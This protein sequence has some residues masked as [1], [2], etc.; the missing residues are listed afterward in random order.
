MPGTPPIRPISPPH[1]G[2]SSSD[3]RASEAQPLSR[4]GITSS[5]VCARVDNTMGPP[6]PSGGSPNTSGG[7]AT[8]WATTNSFGD[9]WTDS[10]RLAE[11]VEFAHA[12]HTGK[13]R[14]Y[15]FDAA[16]KVII[17]IEAQQPQFGSRAPVA[18]SNPMPRVRAADY[19]LP[20]DESIIADLSNSLTT[21]VQVDTTVETAIEDLTASFS[22]AVQVDTTVHTAI[23]DLSS[24]FATAVLAEANPSRP[25]SPEDVEMI[26]DDHNNAFYVAD[27]G[28]FF[29]M[30]AAVANVAET[31]RAQVLYP[32]RSAV[33]NGGI[34][35]PILPNRAGRRYIHAPEEPQSPDENLCV[36]LPEAVTPP[37]EQSI[38]EASGSAISSSNNA[39]V[40]QS[41]TSLE[42]VDAT[43]TTSSTTT[44]VS[45]HP[46]S[47]SVTSTGP[48]IGSPKAT[49]TNSVNSLVS[50]QVTS[51]ELIVAKPTPSSSPIPSA[52]K[53]D[54]ANT[55][56]S[57]SSTV[58]NPSDEDVN[59][60]STRN[61]SSIGKLANSQ[62]SCRSPETSIS[63][64]N[65]S[66]VRPNSS[67]ATTTSSTNVSALSSVDATPTFTTR[68]S[69]PV[70]PSVTSTGPVTGSSTA[71]IATTSANSSVSPLVTCTELVVAT[72]TSSSSPIP[73]AAIKDDEA[74]TTSSTSS[75]VT[76][77]SDKDVIAESTANSS[78]ILDLANTQSSCRSSETSISTPNT[79]A[80]QHISS[81]ATTS[82]IN[83]SVSPVVNA[84][85]TS[86]SNTSNVSTHPVSP[87]V[88]STESANAS[89]STPASPPARI[90][91]LGDVARLTRP[92][93]AEDEP[94][95]KRPKIRMRFHAEMEKQR[96]E[97]ATQL[98]YRQVA[99]VRRSLDRRH[100]TKQA[101]LKQLRAFY[102]ARKKADEEAR[103]QRNQRVRQHDESL[104]ND[105]PAAQRPKLR[106]RFH[107]VME[108]NRREAALKKAYLEMARRRAARDLQHAA[109]QQ[110]LEPQ[111]P[112]APPVIPASQPRSPMADFVSPP[113]LPAPQPVQRRQ[114]VAYVSPSSRVPRRLVN[115]DLTPPPSPAPVQRGPL[116][117]Y[118]SLP[119]SPIRPS[120]PVTPPTSANIPAIEA[121]QQP[122]TQEAAKKDIGT[123]CQPDAPKPTTT[124][125]EVQTD[126]PKTTTSTEVQTDAPKTS[127]DCATQTDDIAPVPIVNKTAT[128]ETQTPI[129][130]GLDALTQTEPASVHSVEVQVDPPV[131][132]AIEE[133]E[134]IVQEPEPIIAEP[135]PVIQEPEPEIE[136]PEP[137]IV[138]EEPAPE[139]VIFEPMPDDVDGQSDDEP[140]E[141]IPEEVDGGQNDP[142]E[143]VSE[144]GDGEQSDNEPAE[145]IPEEVDSDQDEPE[146]VNEP[147]PPM[148]D[149]DFS[150]NEVEPIPD[151]VEEEGSSAEDD[152]NNSV[153]QPIPNAQSRKR[154]RHDDPWMN[155][156]RVRSFRHA[157]LPAPAP[158]IMNQELDSDQEDEPE[159]DPFLQEFNPLTAT[160]LLQEA[161]N[162]RFIT[163]LYDGG[164]VTFQ[165][166]FDG[167]PRTSDLLARALHHPEVLYHNPGD[168]IQQVVIGRNHI[169][170]LSESGQLFTVGRANEGQLG[171]P[172]HRHL[173]PTP[174]NMRRRVRAQDDD[175]QVIVGAPEVRFEHIAA[176]GN[177]TVAWTRDGEAYAAGTTHDEEWTSE[178]F[179][180]FPDHDNEDDIDWA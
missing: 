133:P 142:D 5:E 58:T 20:I 170:M 45:S 89:S 82:N 30:P 38:G 63:T 48:V 94:D 100:V 26:V 97:A 177:I 73:P 111:V 75:N 92:R 172:R 112:S 13:Y 79:S 163:G 159:T 93:L 60:A 129:V 40:S 51:T 11:S 33:R 140:A 124:S 39:S 57:K 69:H 80:V 41:A 166:L 87:P 2:P 3:A 128:T 64:P 67:A 105:E 18:P 135:E 77:R 17:P 10:M 164:I 71:S 81:A 151:E 125:S 120:T 165:G 143:P 146:V 16:G 171:R 53:D 131:D 7:I 169:A 43:Q 23:E 50:P 174:D 55:T 173:N 108:K 149:N 157:N 139:I 134:P 175:G 35:S 91:Q 167:V 118:D 36:F 46:V 95:P 152:D 31:D 25:A 117:D 76:N 27:V 4:V 116:V 156:D 37:M 127:V 144:E 115:Y 52:S 78:S 137:E 168:G 61:S 176:S 103:E 107:V 29:A 180:R 132:P 148:D 160:R 153:D 119:P 8:V 136:E 113:T 12:F 47:P 15:R 141:P 54:E 68:N 28:D 42:A 66:T 14:D 130:F 9:S 123:E 102:E 101:Q 179:T 98:R 44:A 155:L 72:P 147:V 109:P 85:P 162:D 178:F 1:A 150:D 126:A 110:P 121:P 70:S 90:Q 59:A 96:K 49:A 99:L 56:S 161:G 32:G 106:L 22:T 138:I 83:A 88:T 65:T 24:S 19:A 158:L 122:P 154:R 145:S 86:S 62:S 34:P 114:P 104:R 74:N 6:R 21:A 84:T